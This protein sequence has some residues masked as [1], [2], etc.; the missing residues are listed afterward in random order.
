MKQNFKMVNVKNLF[1]E[2][3]NI[4]WND[5]KIQS[6]IKLERKIYYYYYLR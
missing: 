2:N 4:M 6:Y 3:G 5:L 1:K